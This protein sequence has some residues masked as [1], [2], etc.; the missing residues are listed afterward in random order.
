M[1]HVDA[2]SIRAALARRL[3]IPRELADEQIRESILVRSGVFCGRRF[4]LQGFVLTWFVEENEIKLVDPNGRLITSCSASL[5][6]NPEAT[7]RA[8]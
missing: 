4:A 6:T 8:A 7:R 5:F 1:A 3:D 2:P